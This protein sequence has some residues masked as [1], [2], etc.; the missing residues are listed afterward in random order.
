MAELQQ[1]LDYDFMRRA[2]LAALLVGIIAPMVGIFV[3]QRGL[4]LIGDAI[5]HVAL[6][7]VAIGVLLGTE[8]IWSALVVS[9]VAA[10]GIELLRLREDTASDVAI[11][12]LFYAGIALGVVLLSSTAA[13]G[14]ASLQNVLFGAI[15][16][17]TSQDL[18]TFS[19]I[20]GVAVALVLL[21]R[22]RL[23]A[24]AQDELFSRSQ[25]LPVTFLNML[26]SVLVAATI[27]MSMRV[28]GLL[29]V[30]ALMVVPNAAAQRL[31]HGF[32]AAWL[33]A[34]GLGALSSV[35]GVAI[36]YQL[37]LPSGGTIVLVTLALYLLVALLG[38]ALH[39]ARVGR[40]RRSHTDEHHTHEHHPECG[41][42]MVRHGDHVDYRHGGHLHHP[43]GDH[44]DEH[45]V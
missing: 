24:V 43:H 29:L 5:G 9:V 28:V 15:S 35:G 36:S 31:V 44:Y 34:I 40:H 6:A 2:L 14:D 13:G 21:L 39:R 37:D 45:R 12:L 25:G 30:S 27:V 20:G 26:L 38:A 3:V 32:T 11:A 19:V 4:S 1:M 22:H 41:H 16:T 17:T 33:I 23:F 8:P 10:I 7:G 18:V 42:P